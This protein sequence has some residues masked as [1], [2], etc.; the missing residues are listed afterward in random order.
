MGCIVGFYTISFAC[1][2]P[3]IRRLY[4]HARPPAQRTAIPQNYALLPDCRSLPLALAFERQAGASSSPFNIGRPSTQLDGKQS[5]AILH[6]LRLRRVPPSPA[7]ST[8]LWRSVWPTDDK[9][10]HANTAP[11]IFAEQSAVH[12][13][14]FVRI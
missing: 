2:A 9:W 11:Y 12:L 14:A 4:I 13:L 8:D 10:P 5:G 7:A 1:R 3:P 6:V